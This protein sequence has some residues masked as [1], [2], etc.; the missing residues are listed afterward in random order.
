M[1]SGKQN[2][3]YNQIFFNFFSFLNMDILQ[4]IPTCT[5]IIA[6]FQKVEYKCIMRITVYFTAIRNLINLVLHTIKFNN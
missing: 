5:C 3:Y 1:F 2:Y 6:S 4:E